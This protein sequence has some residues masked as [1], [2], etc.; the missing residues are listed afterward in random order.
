MC[1]IELLQESLRVALLAADPPD[2][3]AHEEGVENLG[4][5]VERVVRF[6]LIVQLGRF[7]TQD[8]ARHQHSQ[9]LAA[10]AAGADH[11]VADREEI[12]ERQIV[13]GHPGQRRV[14]GKQ[15]FAQAVEP[16]LFGRFIRLSVGSC[17]DDRT[18]GAEVASPVADDPVVVQPSPVRTVENFRHRSAV[19]DRPEGV[20]VFPGVDQVHRRRRSVLDLDRTDIELVPATEDVEQELRRVGDHLD[21][22]FD[23]RVSPDREVGHRIQVEQARAGETEEIGHHPVRLPGLGEVRK[24]V[25]H[26][27]GFGAGGFDDRMHLIDKRIKPVTRARMV[28]LDLRRSVEQGPVFGKAE[29]DETPLLF[30]RRS[31][32]ARDQ[33]RVFI[34]RL[35][36]PDDVVAA[37]DAAKD[38][39]QSRQTRRRK[40]GGG[41]SRGIL[42]G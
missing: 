3:V 14:G 19:G 16:V 21:R 29:I 36:L 40:K 42:S 12:V 17:L 26:V 10:D 23:V 32:I 2:A 37:P 13:P 4:A 31:G 35:H 1:F 11:P 6:K 8:S 30:D 15:Q 7:P 41:K 5:D 22:R 38:L 39:I 34:E 27:H 33:C 28:D 20:A 9:R 25:E 18:R 24:A